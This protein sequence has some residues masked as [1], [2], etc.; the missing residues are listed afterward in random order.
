[1]TKKL[2]KILLFFI[3]AAFFAI[4]YLSL[5]GFNTDKFNN[6]IKDE[7]KKVDKKIN[8][9]LKSIKYLL[10]PINLSINIKT[11]EPNIFYNGNELEFEYI[12]INISLKSFIKKKFL[13]DDLLISTKKIKLNHIVSLARSFKNSTELFILD[14]IIND[15]FLVGDISLNFDSNGKIKDDY[16]IKGFI[17]NG[18]LS[19]LKQYNIKNLNLLFN[20]KKNQFLLE[21]INTEFNKIE[22]S[23]PSIL[24][25]EKK[26]LFLFSGKILSNEK[27]FN[28]NLLNNLFKD[29]F[30]NIGIKNIKFSSNND[31]FFKFTKKF[32]ISDF[33][34]KSTI[35]LKNLEYKSDLSKIKDYLP[36]FNESIKLTNHKILINYDKKQLNIDGNGNI[37]IE[38]ELD[39]LNYKIIKKKEQYIFE[40]FININKNSLFLDILNY[41]KKKNINS[42]I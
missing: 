25:K 30:K 6:K 26:D 34:L 21:Q 7:I 29:S 13:I 36:S 10:N 24:I 41:Q 39:T 20:I 15:G 38:D 12:K 18:K 40:T 32:K 37:L 14:K 2:I 28:I 33:S 42:L 17:K 27:N 5:F 3:I 16:E 1:M 35:D 11:L 9:E 4:F 22:L 31:F 23:S 8:L 19:I